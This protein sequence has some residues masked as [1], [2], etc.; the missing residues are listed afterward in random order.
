MVEATVLCMVVS[1]RVVDPLHFGSA[2]PDQI[3]LSVADKMPKKVFSPKVFEGAFTTSV[4]DQDPK[5]PDP[6]P[7]IFGPPRSLCKNSKKNLL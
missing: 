3:C 5:N 7:H 4:V 6:D 2:D 1:N